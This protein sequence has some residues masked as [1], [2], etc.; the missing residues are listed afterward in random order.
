MEQAPPKIIRSTEHLLT[1]CTSAYDLYWHI[2]TYLGIDFPWDTVD[3]LS[4]SSP[5]KCIWAVYNTLTT[6]TGPSRHVVCAAR[7]TFKTL[8]SS[9]IQF[10]SM[11]HC[12][13]DGTQIAATLEQ[14]SSAIAYLD[15]YLKIPEV[16]LFHKTDNM[17]TKRLEGMPANEL[18]DRLRACLRVVTATRKGANSQRAS[19]LVFDEVDLI[20][21]EI[22]SEAAFIADP[23]QDKNQF[24]PVFLYLSSR[25]SNSGPIQ[26]LIDEAEAGDPDILLHKWSAVDC[27]QKC[28]SEIHRPDKGKVSIYMHNETLKMTQSDEYSIMPSLEQSKYK[29][30]DV[31]SGCLKCKSLIACQGRSV[32]QRGNSKSLRTRRFVA[33]I[34]KA[35]KIPSQIIAQCL[36]WKPESTA[37]VFSQISAQQHL[38]QPS[39]FYEFIT[40][41]YYNPEQLPADV[42]IERLH[43]GT[44]VQIRKLTPSKH[45][46]YQ[47]MR[48]FGWEI[49]FG[50]DWGF[51]DPAV[52]I[53]VGYHRRRR[54]AVVLHTAKSTGFPNNEWANFIKTSI[55][56]QFKADF[57]APD[58]ADPASP[59]YFQSTKRSPIGIPSLSTKPVRI[60]TGVSQIR[61][62]MWCPIS[63]SVNFMILDDG[64]KD[65]NLW[66]FDC[67]SKWTHKKTPF[68]WDFDKF[69]DDDYT[70]P[71]DA[72]RYALDK[73][74]EEREI[75]IQV[76]QS[77]ISV[78]RTHADDV[79]YNT[80][81]H[82]I[83]HV[84]DIKNTMQNYFATQFGLSNIYTP[85]P[86]LTQKVTLDK[87]NDVDISE[88][89]DAK[90]AEK[91]RKLLFSFGDR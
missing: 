32:K 86:P 9:V 64:D 43:S 34:L 65:G 90:K 61:G 6:N 48:K 70:H 20:D 59:S 18:T 66:T 27:M 47:A 8:T 84:D 12:R 3:E 23:T 41:E 46:I 14:S 40:G 85:T 80:P 31:Y 77:K 42:L 33:D 82:L 89:S 87:I 78:A 4:T 68:G 15:Q 73:F 67:L 35:V 24:N 2:R 36:N 53:V 21:E 56:P 88:D 16:S 10:Y 29:V 69:E 13:R 52:C 60:N 39:E 54:S 22:L 91:P 50:V 45:V 81:S 19:L 76:S 38:A 7:N 5:M 51:T 72:L 44:A 57:V 25:K 49:V 17:K 79:D 30:L 11:L 58:M 74:I 63:M 83:G 55:Y 28:P 26:S 1:P 75:N 62:L 71:I 37:N